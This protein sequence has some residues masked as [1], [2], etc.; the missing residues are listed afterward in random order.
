VSLSRTEGVDISRAA[1]AGGA[2]AGADY[3][4]PARRGMLRYYWRHWRVKYKLQPIFDALLRPLHLK[5]EVRLG[6]DYL[7]RGRKQTLT[8]E[9]YVEIYGADAVR[10]KRF[11]SFGAGGWFHDAW[12]SVDHYVTAPDYGGAFIDWDIS[13]LQPFPV[14]SNTAECAHSQHMIEHLS[15]AEVAFFFR[16]AYR[17]LKPGGVFRIA[18]PDAELAYEMWRR[19]D[20][21]YFRSMLPLTRT[22]AFVAVAASQLVWGKDFRSPPRFKDEEIKRLFDEKGFVAGMDALVALND[23]TPPRTDPANHVSWWSKE[24][25]G[26][27]MREAGFSEVHAMAP[28]QS[29]SPAM[30]D[31]RYFDTNQPCLTLC[32]DGVK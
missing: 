27:M 2:R 17:I 6:D 26:R 21:I 15:D 20:P 28:G 8:L 1:D 25:V 31:P 3:G 5:V 29:I 18:V 9:E 4:A 16:E 23:V 30:R 24:K 19:D 14:A 32:V 7:P 13:L 12:T 10:N 22:Q 11:Y